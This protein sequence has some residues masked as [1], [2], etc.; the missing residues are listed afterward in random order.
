MFN[1]CILHINNSHTNRPKQ[2]DQIWCRWRR[3]N[4]K[5]S[6]PCVP[7]VVRSLVGCFQFAVSAW[8]TL[9]GTN[10]SPHQAT[11]EDDFPYTPVGYVS[12]VKGNDLICIICFF[13]YDSFLHMCYNVWERHSDIIF[14]NFCAQY[15]NF[16]LMYGLVYQKKRQCWHLSRDFL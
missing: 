9:L 1:F 4:L 5:T 14:R 8:F 7:N 12:F 6:I 16:F 3:S 2:L 15:S 13:L 11:F 10:I